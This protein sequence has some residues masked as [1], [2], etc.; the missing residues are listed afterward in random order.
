MGIW[1]S[2]DVFVPHI[3]DNIHVY[4]QLEGF[5]LPG[6]PDSDHAPQRPR[7]AFGHMVIARRSP[8]LRHD[9]TRRNICLSIHRASIFFSGC[10]TR[11]QIV[12]IW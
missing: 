4:E 3:Y 10:C 2:F 11:K 7:L 1:S 12:G 6:Q 5:L 8:I 9:N